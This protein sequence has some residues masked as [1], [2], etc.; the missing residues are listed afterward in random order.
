MSCKLKYLIF[1][2][3]SV[4][5]EWMQAL[6]ATLK[7]LHAIGDKGKRKLRERSA[8]GTHDVI[9]RASIERRFVVATIHA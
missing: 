6:I 9:S 3:E 4:D 7:L 8:N 2:S 5:C 1:R